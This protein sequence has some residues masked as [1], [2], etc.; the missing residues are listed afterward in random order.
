MRELVEVLEEYFDIELGVA[1]F[2]SPPVD[3]FDGLR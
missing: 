2:I 1:D 3:L